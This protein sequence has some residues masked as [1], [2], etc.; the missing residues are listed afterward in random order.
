VIQNTEWHQRWHEGKIGWHKA[1]PNEHLANHFQQ[2]NLTKGTILVPLC[3]KSQDLIW[4]AKQGLS[5]VG[6]EMVEEGIQSFFTEW[7]KTPEIYFANGCKYYRK[8]NI[9]ILHSDFFQ[10]NTEQLP[11]IDAI[12]DRAA[13]VAIPPEIRSKYIS[14]QINLLKKNGKFLLLTYNM[15]VPES[16]GPPYPVRPEKI[17]NLYQNT[18]SVQLLK[19]IKNTPLTEPKLKERGVPWSTVQIWLIEK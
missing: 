1:S 4:L 12:Y 2:L 15:P 11:P 18:S 8:E 19:E 7:G 9:T 6:I 10:V 5:V 16:Q 14:H 17:A 13:L 3:G